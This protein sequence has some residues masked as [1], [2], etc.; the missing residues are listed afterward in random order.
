VRVTHAIRHTLHRIAAHHAELNEHLRATIKTGAS[1]AYLPD[2][3]KPM[4]WEL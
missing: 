2:P 3:R 4:Q 1:C